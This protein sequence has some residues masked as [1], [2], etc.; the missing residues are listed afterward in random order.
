MSSYYGVL[1]I[2]ANSL[3]LR[4]AKIIFSMPR[5][6]GHIWICNFERGSSF[7]SHER[8]T[9]I[10]GVFKKRPN[11][12]HK[13]FIL[14]HFKQC[15]LQ[16]S[17]LYWRHTVPNVSSIVGMLLGRH[18]LWWRGV[19]LSHF[20]E[21][22]RLQKKTEPLNSSLTSTESALQLLS[23]P[24]GRFWQETAICPVSP[25]ALVVELHPLN[26]ARAQAVR[27]INPTCTSCSSDKSDEQL[28]HV[29]SS[30]DVARRLMLTAKRGK[31]QFIVKTCR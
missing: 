17:P 14:Q 12:C 25:W 23:A 2:P 13:D 21:S 29:L 4:Y 9:Y 27:R 3:E 5:K 15:P 24:S 7:P 10:Q 19:L 31:W 1:L 11:V 28:V 6:Y 26:W 22:L 8:S 18:F 30:A 16:T 20:P